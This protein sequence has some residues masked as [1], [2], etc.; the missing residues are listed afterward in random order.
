MNGVLV[1]LQWLTLP[2][3][4]LEP[5]EVENL[6]NW[7][8]LNL[9]DCVSVSMSPSRRCSSCPRPTAA[10]CRLEAGTRTRCCSRRSSLEPWTWV[11]VG[12]TPGDD[13][14]DDEDAA[15]AASFLQWSVKWWR[16]RRFIVLVPLFL[17]GGEV[18]RGSQRFWG[19]LRGSAGVTCVKSPSWSSAPTEQHWTSWL[20]FSTTEGN[21]VLVLDSCVSNSRWPETERVLWVFILIKS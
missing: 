4:P 17:K 3:S 10:R 16:E 12:Q 9:T 11:K 5:L 1:P 15:L 21:K 19:V 8:Q 18:L 20:N 2:G 6:A 13:C 14:E 7:P